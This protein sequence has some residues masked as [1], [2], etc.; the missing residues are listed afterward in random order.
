MKLSREATEEVERIVT[1]LSAPTKP[2]EAA[3]E[4][5]EAPIAAID[6]PPAHVQ[7]DARGTPVDSAHVA[8]VG[9][10]AAT[11]ETRDKIQETPDRRGERQS[12]FLESAR[13]AAAQRH[14]R[15]PAQPAANRGTAQAIREIPDEPPAPEAEKNGD[16]GPFD[17]LAW[18]AARARAKKESP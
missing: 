13:K 1:T 3:A 10:A 7:A 15:P 8:A 17:L 14:F 16:A 2:L 6:R 12:S 18:R 9:E 5:A 11:A 4:A